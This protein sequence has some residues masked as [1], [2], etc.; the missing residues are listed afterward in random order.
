MTGTSLRQ[1]DG[2]L[3]NHWYI[4][5]LSSELSTCQAIARTVYENPYVLYR[6][7][8]GKPVGMLDRCIH[9]GVQLSK[10]QC[11]SGALRCPYHGW[12]YG[13]DGV[14]IEIP[15]EAKEQGLPKWSGETVPVYEQDGAVWIWVGDK[16]KATEKPGW[17][18]PFYN[19]N[20]W[21]Q[22]FMI[23]DFTNEVTHLTQNFM[24]VPHTVFVHAKWFRNRRLIRVPMKVNVFSGHVKVTYEQPQDSIG[25]MERIMNPQKNPMIHTDEFI[26]P[27]LTRVDYQFGQRHF[28]INSQCTPVGRSQTRVYTW[29]C[30]RLGPVMSLLKPFLKLYT[31]KVIT[32][33]VEIMQNHGKN[34]DKFRDFFDHQLYKSTQA[35]ELHIAIDKMRSQG[36]KDRH[37][38]LQTNYS[39]E[40]EF[41]I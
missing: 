22:Y 13:K 2:D 25:F 27:N 11:K 24:D 38:P 41:W 3:I 39:R 31:R 40:R 4:A 29:I 30:Y 19:E 6:D 1:A 33:D 12:T 10:G 20:S 32:Q 8:D 26:F 36:V 18:F 34:L 23:T 21:T 37:L 5:C 14:V 17:R 35:D 9:R 28:I 7:S 15:S 16:Q